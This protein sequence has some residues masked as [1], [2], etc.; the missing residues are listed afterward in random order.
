LVAVELGVEI[1]GQTITRR[2]VDPARFPP[3]SGL[4]AIAPDLVEHVAWNGLGGFGEPVIGSVLARITLDY[5]YEVVYYPGGDESLAE[6]AQIPGGL[7][8]FFVGASRVGCSATALLAIASG[9]LCAFKTTAKETRSVGSVGRTEV[10]LGAWDLDAHHVYDALAGA[11]HLGDG[12]VRR[13]GGSIS[14]AAHGRPGRRGS[15]G[16][17][18]G[19]DIL[20]VLPDARSCT[21]ADVI[22]RTPP[23]RRPSGSRATS[24]RLDQG[25]DSGPRCSAACTR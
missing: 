1:A 10:G 2:Y 22:N 8:S 11:V 12:T 4:D 19:T 14:A 21:A 20:G 25:C 13:G 3:G 17:P 23:A 7:D 18:I 6:F 9:D 16:D 24:P 15:T 5:Y